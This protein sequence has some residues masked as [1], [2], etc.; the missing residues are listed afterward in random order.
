MTYGFIRRD[1]ALLSH[2]SIAYGLRSF[3]SLCW[4]FLILPIAFTV[5]PHPS[6]EKRREF[7]GPGQKFQI[8]F[9][10]QSLW[11]QDSTNCSYEL[12]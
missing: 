12:I 8:Y 1:A 10:Y 6:E 11:I 5:T 4:S 9:D 2:D 3:P 7:A